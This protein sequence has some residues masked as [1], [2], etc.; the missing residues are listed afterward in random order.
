MQ[1]KMPVINYTRLPSVLKQ[2]LGAVAGR[3]VLEIR[4][5]WAV[6][7]CWV[8]FEEMDLPDEQPV[9]AFRFVHRRPKKLNAKATVKSDAHSTSLPSSRVSPAAKKP[10]T[11]SA[12][13][14]P[15]L[16]PLVKAAKGKQGDG[17]SA[18]PLT[19]AGD[20]A[21]VASSS[22][23]PSGR[24]RRREHDNKTELN[25]KRKKTGSPPPPYSLVNSPKVKA[26]ASPQE[27]T[28]A[29]GKGKARQS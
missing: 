25:I 7:I 23:I 2:Q 8:P 16:F 24:K 20:D 13:L 6:P 10:V 29:K 22:K 19:L 27:K 18:A 5:D 26:P 28:T 11:V 9:V 17:S 3:A 15:A 21:P 4:V 12:S 14:R 1:L